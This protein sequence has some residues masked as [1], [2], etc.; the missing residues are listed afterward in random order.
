[1]KNNDK[2]PPTQDFRC[3]TYA[4]SL[5]HR[6]RNEYRCENCKIA[7]NTYRR[8]L[9][10]KNGKRKI[11]LEKWRKEHPDYDKQRRINNPEYFA[12]KWDEWF[13]ANKDYR[14]RYLAQR[15]AQKKSNKVEFYTE[16]EVLKLYGVNCHICK[17][18]IDLTAPRVSW[19]GKGWK[20]GLQIDHL[21]PI[22]KGGP[23]TLANVRP[24]HAYCNLKKWA[25]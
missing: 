6:K 2:L 4:G 14:R 24:S 8:E 17:E 21:I 25:N 15:I 20:K 5:A 23:D 22:S 10:A 18:P 1:M 16:Q 12:K 13:E 3:G 11:Y 7:E 19:K 9:N